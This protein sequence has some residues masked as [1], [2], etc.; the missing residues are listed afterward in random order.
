MKMPQQNSLCSYLYLKEA[1]V[2][3]FSF[4]FYKIREQEGRTGPVGG[5]GFVP[6]GRGRWLE[7]EL[8]G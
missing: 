4:F 3:F 8:G 5:G 1:K 6:V 7:N 2:S